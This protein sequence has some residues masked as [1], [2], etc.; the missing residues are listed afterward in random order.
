MLLATISVSSFNLIELNI[1][2]L[3]WISAKTQ[4]GQSPSPQ[5]R[6]FW[7]KNKLSNLTNVKSQSNQCL[8]F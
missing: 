1:D 3:E 6:N 5:K 8:P 2:K 4:S 7:K